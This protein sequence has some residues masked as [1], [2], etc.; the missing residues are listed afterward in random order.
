M[1][2]RGIIFDMDGVLI[3]S[4]NAY[5]EFDAVITGADVQRGKPDP[6]VF[7]LA[8][9]RMGALPQCCTVVEDVSV[10]VQAAHSAG[11]RAIGLVSTGRTAEELRDSDHV[12]FHL[13]EI[14]SELLRI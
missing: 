10:G 2:P 4:Y 3:G 13:T 11:M 8:A 9:E 6:Q 12:V 7:L 14:S 5:I 1:F